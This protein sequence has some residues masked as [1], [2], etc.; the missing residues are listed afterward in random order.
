MVFN[1]SSVDKIESGDLV[2]VAQAMEVV[3]NKWFGLGTML[4]IPSKNLN[5]IK[6]TSRGS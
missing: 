1:Y 2:T 6:H 5:K 4:E 3:A